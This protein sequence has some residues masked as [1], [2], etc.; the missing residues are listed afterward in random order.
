MSEMPRL[1]GQIRVLV[2]E[3]DLLAVRSLL[4]RCTEAGMDTRY[5][6][7]GGAALE[8]VRSIQ[9]H[10]ILLGVSESEDE[11]LRL[12]ALIHNEDP[13]PLLVLT[14]AQTD[15]ARWR[16]FMG[17]ASLYIPKDAPPQAILERMASRI[18]EAYHE[19]QL[20]IADT[21][22]ES[23][24]HGLAP[25]WG[26]CQHCGY[27]GPRAKFVDPNPLARHSLICP[28]CKHSDEIVFAVA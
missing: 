14:D 16:E 20:M 26:K 23:P 9:P 22:S 1:E 3:D 13:A 24:V 8:A 18:R 28:V 2:I 19:R 11:D 7:H 4:V 6:P 25:G 12:A 21:P 17:D 5:A 27:I 10:V 15:M